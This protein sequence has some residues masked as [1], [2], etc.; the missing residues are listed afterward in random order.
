MRRHLIQLTC[1]IA[2]IA[3]FA[4]AAAGIPS[5]RG[6]TG[7][8]LIPTADALGEGDWNV[9]LMMEDITDDTTVNDVFANYGIA[10]GV[11]VGLNRF[12]FDD[13]SDA[14]TIING[15]YAFQQETPQRPG[16]AAGI[17]DLTD[18]MDST[19]YVVASKS[20]TAQLG[21]YEGDVINPRVHVGIGGGSLDGLFGGVSAYVGNRIQ[22]MA[23][24]DSE[25]VQLGARL[26]LTPGLTIHAGFFDVGD[27]GDF[28]LGVSF[29]RSY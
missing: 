6:Y 5:F 29:G 7:L 12:R 21:T 1:V 13:D 4:T 14:D 16:I 24:W 8:M 17:M 11:E 28:G 27:D 18:E 10:E 26:R 3:A 2:L 25:N 23:E 9:G 19:V 22:V 20:L 15:K